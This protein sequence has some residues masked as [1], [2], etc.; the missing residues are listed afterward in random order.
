MVKSKKMQESG[1]EKLVKDAD[2]AGEMIRTFQD[3][4]QSVVDDFEKEKKR[5]RNGK[6]SQSALKSSAKKSNNELAKLDKKIKAA[7]AKVNVLSSKI[8]TFATKQRPKSIKVNA[9]SAGK[10]PVKKKPVKKK[11]AKKPAKKKAAKKKPA[12]KKK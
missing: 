12:K 2:V 6:I 9:A 8:K 7:I 11:V 5:F 10:P 1:Y 3:E 4:K